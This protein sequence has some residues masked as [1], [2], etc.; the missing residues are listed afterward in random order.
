MCIFFFLETNDLN[1]TFEFVSEFLVSKREEYVFMYFQW[2]V[3]RLLYGIFPYI[4]T[5]EVICFTTFYRMHGFRGQASLIH[6]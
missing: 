5:A 1:M 2:P 3:D 6:L 4:F